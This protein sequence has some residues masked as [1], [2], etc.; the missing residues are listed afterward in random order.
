M[1]YLSVECSILKTS[2]NNKYQRTPKNHSESFIITK[3]IQGSLNKITFCHEHKVGN[4]VNNKR[5][6]R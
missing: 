1:N 5:I 2:I 3:A 6:K 4:K